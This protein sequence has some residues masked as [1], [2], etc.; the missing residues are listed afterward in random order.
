[1]FPSGESVYQVAKAQ[2]HDRLAEAAN[3]RLVLQAR[4]GRGRQPSRATLLKQAVGL[5]LVVAG[6]R[7][8]GAGRVQPATG[9]ASAAG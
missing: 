7:L 1:M 9:T 3:E 4:A 6:Q 5:A 8:Q 2:R